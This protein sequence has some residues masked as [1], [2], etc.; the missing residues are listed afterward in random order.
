MKNLLLLLI[1][2]VCGCMPLAAQTATV[3]DTF[4]LG[5]RQVRVPPPEGFIDTA[6]KFDRVVQRI[7]IAEDP[8]NET[9]ASYVPDSMVTKLTESQS[10]GLPLFAKFSVS[11]RVK[12]VDCSAEFFAAVVASV[13]ST[14]PQLL[15]SDSKFAKNVTANMNK[16]I[17]ELS[18]KNADAKFSGQKN[19]GYFQEN[20]HLFS[21]LMA[22][23]LDLEGK[24]IP[25]VASGSIVRAHERLIILYVFKAVSAAE[26]A[27]TVVDITKKWTAAVVAANK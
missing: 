9:M 1:V 18:G 12:S 16:A 20:D 7:A 24:S 25:F 10:I 13:K 17:E 19:L 27:G 8:A 22:M 6:T 5:T 14:I 11:R 15:D 26:D 21:F 2:L 3:P 23:N 4:Q